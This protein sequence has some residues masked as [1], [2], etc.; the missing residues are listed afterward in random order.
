MKMELRQLWENRSLR[1]WVMP[2]SALFLLFVLGFLW[3]FWWPN[4]FSSPSTRIIN[5]SRGA[6]FNAVVDSLEANGIIGSRLGLRI[7][8]RVLGWTK[9]MKVG[10]YV[11][12][13]GVS[14]FGILRDLR[15][16]A[17]RKL[18]PVSIPEGMRIRSIAR[19]LSSELGVDSAKVAALCMS[20]E[21]ASA[22]GLPG[23]SL[24]GYLLP[25]TYFF[26]WQTE[27][28]RIVERLVTA[29]KDFY[30]DSLKARQEALGM[31]MH[32]VVTFA[33]IVEGEALLDDERP[34]ISG[35]YHN[36][37]KK[38]MR[39]EADPTVQYALPDG[40]RR[41]LYSDLK[42]LS[43]YNTY[44]HYGLP[45]GPIN[46]P[47]RKAILATL[48]PANHRYLY[49][50]ADGKGGHIFSTNYAEHLRAVQLYRRIRREM[51]RSAGMGG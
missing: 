49:F 40:P 38:R 18:I 26:H 42:I 6:T 46:N 22:F 14:N 12:E 9:E 11:F 39:L 48:Y 5:V 23:A 35:V 41:L 51:R 15:D 24:E 31:S 32:E 27:E 34:I 37:L 13:S 21:T 3:I 47:G 17:S 45:P 36:R 10:R 2:P 16:G 29:F 19:R 28:E 7:A 43:P 44:R 4:M 20:G 1:R 8:G 50:V 33:S 30:D 25:D